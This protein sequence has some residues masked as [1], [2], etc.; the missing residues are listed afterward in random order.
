[1]F[2]LE[3]FEKLNSYCIFHKSSCFDNCCKETKKPNTIITA[4]KKKNEIISNRR[5]LHSSIKENKKYNQNEIITEL[6]DNMIFK[7]KMIYHR[8]IPC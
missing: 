4:S 5:G 6:K 1:M 2:F 8:R 3:L 7:N